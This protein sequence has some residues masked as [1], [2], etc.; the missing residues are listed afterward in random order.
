ME[1]P[2]AKLLSSPA[3]GAAA[4]MAVMFLLSAGISSADDEVFEVSKLTDVGRVVTADLA[5]F[6]G[7]GRHELMLVTLDG[8]PPDEV[9]T[10]HVYRQERTGRFA[11]SPEFDVIV[12]SDVAIY[13]IADI[14]DAPGDELILLC[15]DRVTVLSV[16]AGNGERWEWLLDGPTTVGVAEDERGFERFR[17][18]YDDFD[19]TPWLLVPQF[20]AVSLLSAD[21]QVRARLDVG[22]RANYYVASGNGL[23]SVESDLQLYY[24]APKI[25]VGDI[26]GD[27]RADI[28]AATRHEL[29]VFLRGQEGEFKRRADYAEPL[30]LIDEA[31]HRRGTGSV[32]TSARDIDADGRL[33]LMISHI[34]GTMIS[35]VTNTR[36]YFNREGRWDLEAPDQEFVVEGSATSNLLLNIDRTAPLELV[37]LQFKFSILEIVELLLTREVDTEILIHRLQPDGHFGDEPW[38]RK[39]ISTGISFDTF[40]PKGF[41]PRAGLDLNGDGLMDFISSANGEGIEVFLGGDKGLF[42]KRSAIQRFPTTGRIHIG[43]INDDGLADFVL[44]DPQSPEPI[45]RI[46][47]N[48]GVLPGTPARDEAY[49]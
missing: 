34:E 44:F 14:K 39:K 10:I 2:D 38:S 3:Y 26:D 21:G 35:T 48:R 25:S 23:V 5:D 42:D 9:R 49:P 22:G 36:V 12:P 18:A 16:S 32:V 31:D 40:R 19:E 17:L 11:S 20:G 4:L 47:L 45:V 28:L 30:E 27:G 41:M 24:D 8:M 43:D 29:R 1:S 6:D 15:P 37:R 7:D 46:G 33:D 13:D